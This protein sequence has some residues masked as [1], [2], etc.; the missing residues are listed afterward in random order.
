MQKSL[1]NSGPECATNYER[2]VTTQATL[3]VCSEGIEIHAN[4]PPW[5]NAELH[6]ADVLVGSGTPQATVLE[7]QH[8]SISEDERNAREA[9]Y[10]RRH[11]M[12]WLV[13]VHS[14]NSFLRT[15]FGMSLDFGLRVIVLNGKEF[16]VMR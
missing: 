2:G 6:R 10:R 5:L 3:V 15:Y 8:S 11:R 7:L 13:H 16:A 9:F 12:F 14:E 1:S 4:A